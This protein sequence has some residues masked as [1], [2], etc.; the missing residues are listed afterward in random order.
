MHVQYLS[1][2]SA[3]LGSGI[4]PAHAGRMGP[5]S[6][7]SIHIARMNPGYNWFGLGAIGYLRV[8][9]TFNSESACPVACAETQNLLGRNSRNDVIPCYSKM[10]DRTA[11]PRTLQRLRRRQGWLKTSCRRSGSNSQ[12]GPYNAEAAQNGPKVLWDPIPR[13]D[14]QPSCE[15]P[16]HASTRSQNLCR[17]CMA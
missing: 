14:G 10:S 3:K 17:F 4:S 9:V 2:L 11:L 12:P 5:L 13:E 16:A 7:T 15:L 8:Q 6:Y 1:M